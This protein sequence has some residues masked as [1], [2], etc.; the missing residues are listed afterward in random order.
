MIKVS[1]NRLQAGMV[2][3][4]PIVTK[5]GQTIASAGASLTSQ[6]IAKLSF[7]RIQTVMI[8]ENSI[9]QEIREHGSHTGSCRAKAGG[10]CPKA[11]RKTGHR[12]KDRDS[13]PAGSSARDNV[14]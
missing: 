3:A 9:P 1:V 12:A 14:A 11:G 7:Y 2:V 13:A 6:L 8:D 5:S 10:S 4:E